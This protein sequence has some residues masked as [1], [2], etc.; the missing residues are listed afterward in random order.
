[1]PEEQQYEY[2]Y[3]GEL[4]TKVNDLEERQR[5][6]KERV[7]LLGSNL[8]ET[9]EDVGKEII[10]I[11]ILL[12][13]MKQDMKRVKDAI[14]RLSDDVDKRAR[15]NEVDLLAK[16]MKMFEPFGEKR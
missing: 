1:M 9:K 13:E 16:Q 14:L 6:L 12:E 4:N 2:N 5:L 15:K 3:F 7:I 11:K 10:N 8:I